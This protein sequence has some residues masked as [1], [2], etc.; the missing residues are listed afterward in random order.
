M[1]P[2]GQDT[3][4]AA[5]F[6][7]KAFVRRWARLLAEGDPFY[8]PLLSSQTDH[9]LGHLDNVF[10]P[11]RVRPVKPVLQPLEAGRLR[12]VPPPVQYPYPYADAAP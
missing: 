2:E 12:K 9:A 7:G 3:P 5:G 6:D 4:A 8:S 11:V 10:A 1:M